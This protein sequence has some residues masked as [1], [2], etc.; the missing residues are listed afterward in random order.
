[1]STQ[2]TDGSAAVLLR[3]AG[4]SRHLEADE[5]ARTGLVCAPFIYSQ[6]SAIYSQSSIFEDF[7]PLVASSMELG[8][9]I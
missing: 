1:M 9:M 8:S 2:W 5:R 7:L 4:S 3:G 6:H